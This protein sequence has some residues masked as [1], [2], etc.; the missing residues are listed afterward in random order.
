MDFDVELI[1]GPDSLAHKLEYIYNEAKEDFLRVDADVIPNG[2][3][4]ELDNYNKSYWWVQARV[5]DLYKND[6]MNGGIQFIKEPAIKYLK[7]Y[8][9]KHMNDERPETGVWRE[10]DINNHTITN[11]EVICGVHGFGQKDLDRVRATKGRRN[12]TD[13]DF[14]LSERLK[15]FYV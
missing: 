15:E 2:N 7:K 5:F 3:V 10:S 14:K 9:S 11:I 13:Y 1:K 12:Q 4:L 8:I 6:L